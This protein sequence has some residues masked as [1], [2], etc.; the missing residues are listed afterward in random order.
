MQ[1]KNIMN[2]LSVLPTSPEQLLDH[3]KSIGIAYK[4]YHHQAVFT[5]AE[6]QSVDS[7]I[8]AHHTRNMFLR[9]KKKQNYLVTLSHDTPIDLKKLE[10]LFLQEF[11]IL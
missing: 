3:L 9:T 2:D 1:G 10:D 5:V 7:Q 8:P 11:S 6:S 4:V